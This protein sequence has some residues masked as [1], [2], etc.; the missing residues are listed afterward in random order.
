MTLTERGWA[1]SGIAVALVFLWVVL[2]EIEFLAGGALVTAGLVF[3]VLVTRFGHP[4]VAVT[5][6]LSPT[7]VHEG[8]EAA[9]DSKVANRGRYALLNAEF[10][11]DVGQ[12]GSAVFQ[13]GRLA[14]RATADAAY[15]IV[16]RPR[17]AGLSPAR[18]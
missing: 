6:H 10:T 16:C 1:F 9:V 2:G 5:R 3:S 11:D 12:L 18:Q 7:L 4:E 15:R 17:I 8:D 14:S 13:I